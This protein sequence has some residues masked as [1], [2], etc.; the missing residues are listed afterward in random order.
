MVTAG[1]ARQPGMSRTDLT[2]VNAAIVG[3]VSENIRLHSPDA[4][5]IVVTNPLDEMTHLAWQTTG[6]PAPRMFSRWRPTGPG[7]IQVV[8]VD[9]PDPENVLRQTLQAIGTIQA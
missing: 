6:F 5:V 3:D 9:D 8:R 2:A 1:R 7:G 4:I